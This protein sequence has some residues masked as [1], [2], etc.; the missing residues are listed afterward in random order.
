MECE[1]KLILKDEQT[2]DVKLENDVINYNTTNCKNNWLY[3]G[4]TYNNWLI[5]PNSNLVYA[6]FV[7]ISG[8][9]D[10]YTSNAYGVWPTL[11]LK[12]SVK[13]IDGKGTIDDPFV[14]G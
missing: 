8:C 5:S 2:L 9:T 14:L 6:F 4:D 12:P 1:L 11:Y 7:Y 3:E 10:T 13:I